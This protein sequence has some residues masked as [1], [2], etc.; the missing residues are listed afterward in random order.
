MKNTVLLLCSLLAASI[1]AAG[2]THYEVKRR[3]VLG[4]EGGWDALTYDPAHHR[5]FISRGTHVM[6]V[7]PASGKAVGDIGDTPGVH[8]IA[9]APELGKGF[10][11]AGRANKAIVFDMDSLK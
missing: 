3:Y 8:A 4:G 11:T 6:V 10:I 9:F 5:L 2:A 7:D 1:S